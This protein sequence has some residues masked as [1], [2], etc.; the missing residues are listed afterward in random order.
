[1]KLTIVAATGSTGRQL[2][3]HTLAA[4]HDVTA[5]VRDRD[6]LPKSPARI[7]TRIWLRRTREGSCGATLFMQVI[8]ISG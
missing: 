5:I 6:K 7:V 4:G 2:L 8:G 3:D 1:M